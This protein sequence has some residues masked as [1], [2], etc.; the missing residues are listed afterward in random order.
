M[1]KLDFEKVAYEIQ[2]WI[3]TYINSAGANGVVV[4]LSGGID[5]AVTATL[6]VNALGAENVIGV[7]LPCESIPEDLKDARLVADQ[8]DCEFKI[9]DLTNPY[10]EL[11][12]LLTIHEPSTEMA[13]ANIKPRLRMTSLYYISQAHGRTLVAG[14]GNRAEMQL[15]YFTKYGDGGVDFEPIGDLY[16]CEVCGIARVLNL[17]IE[18]IEKPPSAG[19]WKGQTDEGEMGITY[20]EIDTI[21]YHIDYELNMDHLNQENV[22]KVKTMISKAQH[23]LLMPPVYRIKNNQKVL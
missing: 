12:N 20:D 10:L 15:G 21:L 16:K 18:I 17:P 1:R 6:C 7:S 23:K 19:L 9:I 11:R 8:L 13:L 14:T 22:E 3:K 5:S 4:G 2:N